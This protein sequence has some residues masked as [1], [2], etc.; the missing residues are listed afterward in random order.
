MQTPW[1]ETV[2]P[3]SDD[4]RDI[5]LFQ[6]SDAAEKASREPKLAQN[7]QNIGQTPLGGAT[8]PPSM[9]LEHRFCVVA[10]CD[11]KATCGPEHNRPLRCD[12]HK[13][14]TDIRILGRGQGG[15]WCMEDKCVRVATCGSDRSE[16]LYCDT[17]SRPGLVKFI[18]KPTLCAQCYVS[19]PVAPA[20]S[21]TTME[22]RYCAKCIDELRAAGL[23]VGIRLKESKPRAPQ[24]V[25]IKEE[26]GT[27]RP[28]ELGRTVTYSLYGPPVAETRE[29]VIGSSA[30]WK[31]ASLCSDVEVRPGHYKV[32]VVYGTDRVSRWM[33]HD[34]PVWSA[35]AVCVGIFGARPSGL[36][37]TYQ[38]RDQMGQLTDEDHSK[39]L[40]TIFGQQPSIRLHFYGSV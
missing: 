22:S 14:G 30:L 9:G 21:R 35:F 29:H 36:H 12:T 1:K 6:L 34:T 3:L 20:S 18:T 23:G 17:H 11:R 40:F 7:G 27:A 24:V 13:L 28:S 15:G 38:G 2:K 5:D 33:R 32:I 25:E 37:C 39:P 8:G 31:N 26:Q 10:K 19:S 16:L 4:E